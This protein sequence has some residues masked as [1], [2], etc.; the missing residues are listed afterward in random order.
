MAPEPGGAWRGESAVEADTS[1]WTTPERAGAQLGLDRQP[2]RSVKS[3]RGR[4]AVHRPDRRA[5][6][7]TKHEALD[8]ARTT[9]IPRSTVCA[10]AG[11]C[12]PSELSTSSTKPCR[13]QVGAHCGGSAR[14]RQPRRHRSGYSLRSAPSAGLHD[15]RCCIQLPTVREADPFAVRPRAGGE[16][17]ATIRPAAAPACESGSPTSIL[18]SPTKSARTRCN[19]RITSRTTLTR[20]RASPRLERTPLAEGGPATLRRRAL[21][22]TAAPAQ[23]EEARRQLGRPLSRPG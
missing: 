15:P 6:V 10:S 22:V 17:M 1:N 14:P 12:L 9:A 13:G 8:F 23:R 3:R 7:A 18:W 16:P 4:C 21:A 19:P 20:G 2:Q 11:S 5:A